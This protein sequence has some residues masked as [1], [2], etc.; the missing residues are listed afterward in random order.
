MLSKN[1]YLKLFAPLVAITIFI[2]S[3]QST[4]SLPRMRGIPTDKIAHFLAFGALSLSVCL[5]FSLESWTKQ[6]FKTSLIVFSLTSLYGALDE[7]HQHFVDYRI[8]SFT[9]WVA[10]S[11]GALA[12]IFLVLFWVKCLRKVKT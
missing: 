2:L 7:F 4:I 6:S 5:W 8:P 3:S 9:D 10:D 11:L 12:G 1:H